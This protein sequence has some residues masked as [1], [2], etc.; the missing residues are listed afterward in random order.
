LSTND[1]VTQIQT[2]FRYMDGDVL[3]YVATN[4]MIASGSECTET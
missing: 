1:I 4:Q 2:L 3:L